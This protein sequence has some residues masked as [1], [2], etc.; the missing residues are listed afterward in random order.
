[1]ATPSAGGGRRRPRVA[2]FYDEPRLVPLL[3]ASTVKFLT[4]GATIVPFQLLIRDLRFREVSMI[5]GVSSLFVNA[6]KI[7]LAFAG[8]GAWA[9]VVPNALHGVL[10]LAVVAGSTRFRPRLRF[11]WREIKGFVSFGVRAAA[12]T[13][14]MESSRN[15]DYFLVGKFLG[16]SALGVYRVAFEVAMMPMETLAQTTYRVAYRCSPACPRSG[17]GSKPHSSTPPGCC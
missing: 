15:L 1:V 4:L 8:A 9:L 3:W 17:S 6:A 12:S 2:A 16:L 14:L 5:Q 10:F 11:V 13:V 7:A